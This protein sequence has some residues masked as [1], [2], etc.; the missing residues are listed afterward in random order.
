MAL[1]DVKWNPSRRDLRQFSGVLLPGFALVVAAVIVYRGGSWAAAGWTAGVGVVA[2]LLGLAAPA[3]ARAV[4]VGWMTLAYPIGWALS[5]LF[6][7][8]VY[9]LVFL[10]IGLVL[11]LL[12][13][14]PLE[15]AMNR[16]APTRWVAREDSPE[17][18]RYFRQF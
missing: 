17:P 7:A 11:R 14:D 12:G 9:F 16:T 13:R 2:G 1:L 8:A 6:L 15:R 4:F 5:H 18:T 10:P 3:F